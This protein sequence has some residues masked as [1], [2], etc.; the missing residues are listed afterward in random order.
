M[1]R[2][3]Y[4]VIYV[5]CII[6]NELKNLFVSPI[7][8]SVWENIGKSD[9]D[10]SRRESE[11]TLKID[12]EQF[13]EKHKCHV[14]FQEEQSFTPDYS[15]N[16]NEWVAIINATKP[17]TCCDAS[18]SVDTLDE[19]EDED[20]LDQD[21]DDTDN[22][23]IS[24]WLKPSQQE[25]RIGID[26][27]IK[28]FAIVAVDKTFNS[29]PV[30]VGAE[31]YDLEQ[32]GLDRNCD[33]NDLVVHIQTKTVLMNWMQQP[34]YDSILPHVDRVIVHLEQLSIDNKRSKLF[35]IELGQLLQRLAN[36]ETCIV[37]LS[38]PHIHR[39]SGPM[40][41]LGD[42]IVQACDLKPIVYLSSSKGSRKRV[43]SA[44]CSTLKKAKRPRKQQTTAQS[45]VEPDNSSDTDAADD[46]DNNANIYRLKKKMSSDI[47]KYFIQATLDQQL[48]LQVY[49]SAE[50]QLRWR[51]VMCKSIVKKFDDLG[52]SLL[53]ALNKILCGS[54]NYRP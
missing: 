52:D 23:Q 26:Q 25:R 36:V 13:A 44:R 2:Q 38:Q 39:G 27:G 17:P 42:K 43:A 37:K 54:S 6:T 3:I 19:Q 33:V 30:V 15:N 21:E 5:E 28:N 4:I 41:N 49:I 16:N 46:P 18:V 29:L 12:A 24:G 32:Q 51:T 45:D 20:K 34:G 8:P 9:H 14:Q 50:V 53:H 35:T 10:K 40:F 11:K 1:C 31:L 22:M 7:F 47:F 48:D